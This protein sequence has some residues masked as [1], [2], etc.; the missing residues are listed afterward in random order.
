MKQSV[1]LPVAVKIR[2]VVLETFRR[3]LESDRFFPDR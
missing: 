1:A 2:A 3:S